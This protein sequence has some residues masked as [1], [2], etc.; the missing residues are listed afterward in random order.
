MKVRGQS[1]QLRDSCVLFLTIVAT[2]QAP[3]VPSPARP[4]GKWQDFNPPLSL[5]ANDIDKYLSVSCEPY[6]RVQDP[7]S[8]VDLGSVHLLFPLY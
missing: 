4:P 3:N 1:F 6:L 7:R 5:F 2:F 8:C